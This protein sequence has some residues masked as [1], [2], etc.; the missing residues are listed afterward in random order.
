MRLDSL[1]AAYI[2]LGL[3]AV[4]LVLGIIRLARDELRPRLQSRTWLIVAAVFICVGSWLL[5]R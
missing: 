3:G 4:F 2:L 5:S 1:N